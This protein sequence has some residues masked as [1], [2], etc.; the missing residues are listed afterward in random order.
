MFSV[1]RMI[2]VILFVLKGHLL[3]VSSAYELWYIAVRRLLPP[4]KQFS[5]LKASNV[6]RKGLQIPEIFLRKGMNRPNTYR[7]QFDSFY[8]DPEERLLLRDGKPVPLTPKV[9]DTPLVLVENGGH[10][11]LKDELMK[12]VWPNS[13]VEE[14]SLARN[15][16]EF[17]EGPG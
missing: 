15:I 14:V 9:F 7:Y 13:F 3:C 16:S 8:L 11:V 17:T 5:R 6:F 12:A 2:R 10:L 4:L 1:S